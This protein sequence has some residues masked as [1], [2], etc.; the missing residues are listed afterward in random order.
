MGFVKVVKSKAYYKRFQ[1]KYRRR[2]EAKTDYYARQRLVTQDKNKYSTPKYRFVVRITNRDVICQIFAADLTHDKC[3]MSAYSHELSRY[4]LPVKGNTNYATAYA[5][6]LLLARR[7]NQKYGLNYEGVVEA[8]GEPFTV[9]PHDDDEGAKKPFKALLD[10]GLA[11]TTTGARIFGA[12]KGAVDGGLNIPHSEKRFPGSSKGEEGWEYDPE[13]HKK[14]IFGSHVAEYM[15]LLEE[16]DDAEAYQKQF[17]AF[18]K[19]GVKAGT[20]ES[21]YKKM[22]AAIRKDPFVK[23]GALELG[24]YKTRK[25]AKKAAP[26]DQKTKSYKKIRMSAKERHNRVCQVLEKKGVEKTVIPM[27]HV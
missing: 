12:L 23:R 9:E 6:G 5:T 4:G 2:R 26:A 1:V 20:I 22:H 16:G 18:I 7:V 3:L 8:T 21:M 11:R 25:A 15:K 19:A 24:K 27:S 14:L 10:V 17:S 13:L